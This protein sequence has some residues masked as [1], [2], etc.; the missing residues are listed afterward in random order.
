MC[1]TAALFVL[2]ELLLQVFCTAQQIEPSIEG[3]VTDISNTINR[4][5]YSLRVE[6]DE[7]SDPYTIASGVCN[8]KPKSCFILLEAA[9]ILNQNKLYR[10]ELKHW[11]WVEE[12]QIWMPPREK[13]TLFQHFHIPKTGT[14][15]VWF[16]SDYLE[17]E[18]DPFNP[19]SVSTTTVHISL[20]CINKLDNN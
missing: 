13:E 9:I 14:S 5:I 15:I 8:G 19:C 11:R 16:L 1:I 20:L 12:F 18:S 6:F 10:K 17:C 7:N 3:D 2:F 4:F